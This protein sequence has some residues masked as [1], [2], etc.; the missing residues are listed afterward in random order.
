M[1]SCSKTRARVSISALSVLGL[2]LLALTTG[3]FMR[4]HPQV[5]EASRA[6]WNRQEV[7]RIQQHLAGAEQLLYHADT[8]RFSAEQLKARKTNIALLHGYTEA[9]RFPR[10]LDFPN[11]RRPYFVDDRGVQCA[12]A[13][14][15]AKSGRTDIVERVRTTNN[16][17]YIR[18]L[19][20]DTALLAWLDDAGL[21][22]EEA[23]R[24]QP[25]YGDYYYSERITTDYAIASLSLSL[26]NGTVIAWNMTAPTPPEVPSWRGLFGV[27]TGGA[28]I[29][30]GATHF[31]DEGDWRTV[32]LWNAA[33]GVFTAGVGLVNL[34]RSNGADE[35]ADIPSN[36]QVISRSESRF[37][38]SLTPVLGAV[39]G[40]RLQFNF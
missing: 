40:A 38:L 29:F 37:A 9:G 17:A 30:L 32:G 12:M 4:R 13:Y 25:T 34:V 14:L 28:S 33:V 8:S 19:T 23:A 10:N 1:A 24:I 21:S 16:N 11:E 31:D 27:M 7:A 18:D 22:V 35:P 3:H 36:S 2:T 26:I 39:P 6:E 5:N 15:I 20:S